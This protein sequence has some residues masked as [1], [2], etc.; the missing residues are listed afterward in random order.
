[1][2]SHA[3]PVGEDAW[4]NLIE[5]ESRIKG[6]DLNSRVDILERY[7]L[8]IS[9]EFGSIRLWK[10]YC[11]YFWNLYLECYA[12]NTN[13]R[14]MS[15]E[16][17]TVGRDAFS[18]DASLSLWQQGYEATKYRLNDSHELWNK[19]ISLE[20]ELLS[21]SRT[22]EGVRRITH[23]FRNRLVTPH[24]TWDDTSQMFSTFLSEYNRATYET[25]MQEITALARDVRKIWDNRE[26]FELRLSRAQSEGRTDQEKAVLLEYLEW[27]MKQNRKEP[28][29][30]S[31][32][33]EICLGLFSRALT[34][35]CARDD[36]V[37]TDY[38]VWVSSLY[39]VASS[40]QANTPDLPRILPNLLDT[41]QHAVSHCSWT[42]TLWA[43]YI[44]AAEEA[45]LSYDNIE[46]IKHAATACGQLDRDGMAGVIDL[47]AAW[48]G[49]LKRRAMHPNATDEDSDVA[50]IGLTAALEDVQFWGKRLYG[51]EYKGDPN[52]RLERILIQYLTEKKATVD[53]ARHYWSELAKKPIYADSYNFWLSFYM[54]EMS[55]FSTHKGRNDNTN[56]RSP[57]PVSMASKHLRIPSLAT[58]VLA[59]AVKRTTIDWPEKVFEVYLQHCNDY[60]PPE[61]LRRATD[62]IHKGLKAVKQRRQEE[63]AAAY[64]AQ[65]A[66]YQ[67]QAQAATPALA[68]DAVQDANETSSKKRMRDDDAESA[69]EQQRLKRDRE[70][71]SI[72]V[73]NLPVEATQTKIRQYFRDYG[74]I[75]NFIHKIEENGTSA[76]ALIE[77]NDPEEAQS[78]LLR[79]GKYLGQAQLTVTPATG[80]TIFVTNYPPEAD[81]Q[82]IRDLFKDCGEIF[83]VRMP[84]LKYNS[85]RRFCYVSFRNAEGAA[86]ATSL[87]GKLLQGKYKLEAKY[88]NPGQKKARDGAIEEGREVH[89]TGLH[90]E[91]SEDDVKTVFDKYGTVERVRITRNKAGKSR[92]TAFVALETKEQAE[93]AIAELDKTVFRSQI[94]KVEKS[95]P[96]NFKPVARVGPSTS[97]SPGPSATRDEEGDEA[98]LDRDGVEGKTK[99]ADSTRTFALMGIP[100]TVNDAR[101]RALV[102]PHGHLAKLTLR[103][104]HG[105][106]ILEFADAAVAGKA[107]LSLN[108]TEIEGRKLKTG[109]VGALFHEKSETRID[110]I[111]KK[112]PST[113]AA[114]S[115]NSGPKAPTATATM[116]APPS[117]MVRRPVLGGKPKGRRAHAGLGFSG[118]INK[119]N[120]SDTKDEDAE[121]GKTVPV[122]RSNADFRSLM[123]GNGKKPEKEAANKGKAESEKEQPMA[124]NGEAQ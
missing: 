11:E 60:E 49:F 55:V 104:D 113:T 115:N 94:L 111:D 6:R 35:I 21:T 28:S 41:L 24:K 85:H 53:N 96:T 69:A 18:L 95:K 57:T 117:T 5:E 91:A 89:V 2:A 108:G 26:A 123:L 73:S 88:S 47:Y 76:V 1:M 23:L 101:I 52:Y 66:Q 71:T 122:M 120:K 99:R 106:A 100:D 59:R 17:K 27:E 109:S 74:H 79:D 61:T 16:E 14:G 80:L 87:D 75:K 77:F 29:N 118:S 54:W 13:G 50:E 45:G 68:L 114:T 9:A 8:A 12:H 10:A 36:S 34:G 67:S 30:Q 32:L 121:A 43:R 22:N 92:G 82:Y 4:L 93:A 40:G 98:M 42:G 105:G 39:T 56:G 58:S 3:P 81:E 84:S 112:P 78:A 116:M 107:Q 25:T 51:N 110:R 65:M 44:L 7:K 15:Q 64:S 72:Y 70:N 33:I 62:T 19:W 124:G 46:R 20:M 37:W 31:L 63:Q 103:H 48:C 90:F 97:P 119:A 38:V 86:N 83:S 102:E